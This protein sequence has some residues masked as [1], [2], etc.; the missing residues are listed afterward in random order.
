M[1]IDEDDYH[2]R[3]QEKIRNSTYKMEGVIEGIAD[4]KG[5]F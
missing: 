5:S 1:P 4:L 3:L 2:Q